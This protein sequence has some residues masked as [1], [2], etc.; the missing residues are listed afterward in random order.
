[1]LWLVLMFIHVVN[2]LACDCDVGKACGKG[3]VC[4]SS[5]DIDDGTYECESNKG[6]ICHIEVKNHCVHGTYTN[7]CDCDH[8]YYGQ[9]CEYDS[10]CSP[11]TIKTPQGCLAVS[12]CS[13]EATEPCLCGDNII[14]DGYCVN[15]VYYEKCAPGA[16]NCY[17][18]ENVCTYYGED[19]CVDSLVWG[20]SD[21]DY[22]EYD[23]S[24]GVTLSTCK[25]RD[26]FVSGGT[27]VPCTSNSDCTNQGCYNGYCA[28]VSCS[29]GFWNGTQCEFYSECEAGYGGT[30]TPYEDVVCELC[31]DNTWTNVNVCAQYSDMSDCEGYW[32]HGDNATDRTC[33]PLKS[34]Q[35]SKES[36]FIQEG[37]FCIPCEGYSG[38]NSETNKEECIAFQQCG[39]D[40]YAVRNTNA[41]VTCISRVDCGDLEEL[42]SDSPHA[43]SF[44]FNTTLPQCV[45]D[46][47][48]DPYVDANSK[49][50]LFT[51]GMVSKENARIAFQ[52]PEGTEFKDVFGKSVT[53]KKSK[54]ETAGY[55]IYAFDTEVDGVAPDGSYASCT[56]FPLFGES[57]TC[58]DEFITGIGCLHGVVNGTTCEC[59]TGVWGDRCD[60]IEPCTMCDNGMCE[61][62]IFSCT[63]YEHSIGFHCVD[64]NN[65]DDCGYGT[66]EDGNN[67]YTCTCH[68]YGVL[69]RDESTCDYNCD[70]CDHCESCDI[71]GPVCSASWSGDKCDTCTSG[72]ELNTEC[73]ECEAGKYDGDEDASTPCE[74]CPEGWFSHNRQTAC[75]ELDCLHSSSSDTTGC[76]C[77][78]GW[79]G[80]RCD[81]CNEG[82]PVALNGGSGSCKNNTYICAAGRS[83]ENCELCD[84]FLCSG[85]MLEK[86][87]AVI[88]SDVAVLAGGSRS[89]AWDK[90]L[91]IGVA[92]QR[93]KDLIAQMLVDGPVTVSNADRDTYEICKMSVRGDCATTKK[94]LKLVTVESFSDKTSSNCDVTISD[95]TIVFGLVADGDQMTVC[96]ATGILFHQKL[97]NEDL[98]SSPQYEISFYND[99]LGYDFPVIMTEQESFY[100]DGISFTVANL[101]A[102]ADPCI[103]NDCES[104]QQCV[105]DGDEFQCVLPCSTTPCEHGSC[106]NEVGGFTCNC[107]NGY[108]G[109]R[110]ENNIDDC[111]DCL[112]GGE[113]TDG[114]NSFTC[115]CT[116]TGF[117]VGGDGLCSVNIQ[118]CESDSCKS[119]GTCSDGINSFSCACGPGFKGTYC[120]SE[121]IECP[122]SCMNGGTCTEKHLD[123]ECDCGQSGFE[124]NTTT[125]LCTVNKDDCGDCLNG[126]ECHDGIN[127]FTCDC[128]ETEYNEG[129]SGLCTVSKNPCANVNC[130]H[131]ACSDGVCDCSNTGYTE[132]AQTGKCTV[133][134][135]YCETNPCVNGHCMDGQLGYTCDCYPGWAT[136][137]SGHCTVN[138]DDCDGKV[139]DHGRCVDSNGTHVCECLN[140]FTTAPGGHSCRCGIGKGYNS[141]SGFCEPCAFPDYNLEY[142]AESPCEDFLCDPGQGYVATGWNASEETHC[143]TCPTGYASPLGNTVCENVNECLKNPCG[144]HGTCTDLPGTYSCTCDDDYGGDQC[145][146][147]NHCDDTPCNN[148]EC[149]N[150][151]SKATCN[152]I[153]GWEGDTCISSIDDCFTNACSGH[154]ECIDKHMEYECSCDS[155][156]DGNLCQNDICALIT[157]PTEYINNQCCSC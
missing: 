17:D 153:D 93:K 92:R 67:T 98:S 6:S 49:G 117:E 80:D 86:I 141:T 124:V 34:C 100:R 90:V 72:H 4:C 147:I 27:S 134:I 108:N 133:N 48:N 130:V 149:H 5:D 144:T 32:E 151:A 107:P 110:C 120:D 62:D 30:H 131:G 64:E 135:N 20:C 109:D 129:S 84:G 21:P 33:I 53:V 91:S 156:F 76:E 138:P 94:N 137:G 1:M 36:T 140:G 7:R 126:G 125:G 121:T 40:K 83:G 119:R 41:D 29:T 26:T 96:D 22:E 99:K 157:D 56:G 142:T 54:I 139:C 63:C 122:T 50:D 39:S 10:F 154:G 115:D 106:V 152:C 85:T 88:D 43:D 103:E 2:V 37:D 150:G 69:K 111:V 97:I 75:I 77:L 87:K 104:H 23:A 59:N 13:G 145:Y 123:F 14:T 45:K 78:D 8:P 74:T 136:G 148:G 112:N 114:V 105:P 51:L 55:Y 24:V 81:K 71:T 61:G 82:T 52:C 132:D 113:C 44:C 16:K 118:D 3:G 25:T 60:Q 58:F 127:S 38:R 47:L 42:Q 15:S 12:V 68:D 28:D 57:Q 70:H 9:M 65:C 143:E 46:G 95:F 18:G 66:C 155:G 128:T 73:Q 31:P 19:S 79:S 11:S 102:V 116:G 35:K 146:S 89:K 101:E